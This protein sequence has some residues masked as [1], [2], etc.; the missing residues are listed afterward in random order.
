MER[1]N[2][3]SRWIHLFSGNLQPGSVIEL[4]V[5]SGSMAPLLCP[6]DR[7]KIWCVPWKKCHIGD[8]IIFKE[9]KRFTVHRLLF[10]LVLGGIYI[11]YQKGDQN[12]KGSFISPKQIVGK[13]VEIIK[14]GTITIDLK[15]H[16][17]EKRII[18]EK[19]LCT[20]LLFLVPRY[21]KDLLQWM[22][23]YH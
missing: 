3:T 15:K 9:G 22:I 7:I 10:R 16:S 23:N 8:M 2:D 19:K 14:S 5:L 4:P 17:K 13:A 11:L 1:M 6:G 21:G 12:R 20:L 18:A